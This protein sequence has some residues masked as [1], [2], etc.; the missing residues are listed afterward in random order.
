MADGALIAP[1]MDKMSQMGTR[2]AFQG[3]RVLEKKKKRLLVSKLQLKA[4]SR[5]DRVS[6]AVLKG[7]YLLQPKGR[8]TSGLHQGLHCEGTGSPEWF[9]GLGQLFDQNPRDS[10]RSWVSGKKAIVLGDEYFQS[11][12]RGP[13]TVCSRMKHSGQGNTFL[14]T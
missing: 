9:S 6:L 12:T 2:L 14:F 10:W 13:M 1:G 5:N 8:K 4:K 7:N 3:K 11:Y